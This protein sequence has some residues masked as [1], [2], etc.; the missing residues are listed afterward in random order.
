MKQSRS[1]VFSALL[2]VGIIVSSI[3][4]PTYAG[5]KK[6][7]IPKVSA[8][9]SYENPSF[10]IGELS[11][12]SGESPEKIV[13]KNYGKKLKGSG[14]LKQK[15][16]KQTKKFKNSMGRTVI[17]TTQTFNGV[18][19][20]GTDQ[21]FHINDDGVIECVAGCK[22]EDIE[23][24]VV[25]KS[26]SVKY[27]QE[28]VLN[29]VEKDLGF[30]PNYETTPQ[31]EIILYPVGG[32]YQYVYE[33]EV[34]ASSPY[35]TSCTYYIDAGNLSIIKVNSNICSA[36]QPVDGSGIG[37]LNISKPLKMVRD[38]SGTYL[39]KNTY[40]NFG[41]Y[42][43]D[44]SL[45]GVAYLNLF[46]GTD[47]SFDSGI[48]YEKNAVDAHSNV[49]KAA[50]FFNSAPFY[51]N[52]N[53]DLG[54][55]TYVG[56]ITT[57]GAP[58][59]DAY[60]D[61]NHLSFNTALGSA[62][63]STSCCLDIVV[64]EYVH[65]ILNSE[66]MQYVERE[67]RA[68]HEGV[69]D[70]FGVLGEYFITNEGSTDDWYMGEDLGQFLR[71][72]ANPTINDY[73]DY[74]AY[75]SNTDYDP[76]L[77]G[78]VITKAASL[79]AMGGT[80]NGVTVSSIG[81]NKL[82]RIFYNVINDGYLTSNMS[83]KQFANYAIQSAYL[84]YGINSQAYQSTRDAFVAVGL[85]GAPPTYLRLVYVSN[86]T[87]QLLW[88]ATPGSRVGVYRKGA[89][90]KDE[91]EWLTSTTSTTGIG[92]T[93]LSGSCD[94]YVAYVD[95]SDNRISAFSN[96]LNIN[97]PT[98]S[99]P[100]SFAMTYR[101]GLSVQF[102]WTGT[103]GDTFAV[104]RKISGTND[105]FVK[106]GETTDKQMSVNTLFGKCDFKVAVVS[107]DGIR[108]S[109]FSNVVSV[110]T[111]LNAPANFTPIDVTT[112]TVTFSWDEESTANRYAVYRTAYATTEEP[113]KVAETRDTSLEVYTTTGRYNYQVA[114]VDLEGNRISS[115][116]NIV[117]VQK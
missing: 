30:K 44:Q 115:L 33:V 17:S 69:S 13:Q 109:P 39:L 50:K 3:G 48:N 23:N 8:I 63:V 114:I 90:T 5:A 96:A 28:D 76:H 97:K 24:K 31:P 89:G 40:E 4:V 46:T 78:G 117:T 108:L 111:Y 32:K 37:Q 54:S 42:Y 21:N 34:K 57:G 66:G 59:P 74:N 104:Y 35:Y 98:K 95:A 64:H 81:Y 77:A 62:G 22:V 105:E 99:A 72:C 102:S 84:L 110:E 103:T 68:I 87:V 2:S 36:E 106:V 16:F 26:F 58:S 79:M 93:T 38:D 41:T 65:G 60:G 107:P 47:N 92:V 43:A 29:A 91:P 56:V 101:S 12:K 1:K 113:V 70:V 52:G 10:V 53:D 15:S 100:T 6:D 83:F 94:F 27:S 73:S 18:R 71:D 75:L 25:S 51:R 88:N 61:V 116:S 49:T 11:E 45:R 82:A 9:D 19:V 86:M 55:Y 14:D 7:F 67:E 20:Y 85:F 112:S 80:H